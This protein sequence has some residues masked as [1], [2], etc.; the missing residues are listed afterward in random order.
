MLWLFHWSVVWLVLL[1]FLSFYPCLSLF[2]SGISRV[3]KD[4]MQQFQQRW[5]AEL[6]GDPQWDQ[7][8]VSFCTQFV[9][10]SHLFWPVI[11]MFPHFRHWPDHVQPTASTNSTWF[12]SVDAI[13][14]P[15]VAMI[16]GAMQWYMMRLCSGTKKWSCFLTPSQPW[17]LYSRVKQQGQTNIK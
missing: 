11:V 8:C 6:R 9:M 17:R 2:S 10:V 5:A 3:R 4:D 13:R 1:F 14:I 12:V 15:S 7:S 16:C